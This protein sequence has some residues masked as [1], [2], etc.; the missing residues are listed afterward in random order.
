MCKV[1]YEVAIYTIFTFIFIHI[2]IHTKNKHLWIYLKSNTAG[3]IFNQNEILHG[4]IHVNTL[5]HRNLTIICSVLG[6][7]WNLRGHTIKHIIYRVYDINKCIFHVSLSLN[8]SFFFVLT[9]GHCFQRKNLND[10][11]YVFT[12][13]IQQNWSKAEAGISTLAGVTSEIIVK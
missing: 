1:V 4:Y 11:I 8:F 13:N 7:R 9:S 6:V 12:C 5:E 3:R 10:L 2:Y